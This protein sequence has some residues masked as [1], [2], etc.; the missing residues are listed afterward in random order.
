M[1]LPRVFVRMIDPFSAELAGRSRRRGPIFVGG[2]VFGPD[3]PRGA[4]QATPEEI[5]D[6]QSSHSADAERMPL[7]LAADEQAVLR[8]TAEQVVSARVARCIIGPVQL[9]AELRR[10]WRGDDA[11]LIEKVCQGRSTRSAT[12]IQRRESHDPDTLAGYLTRAIT[13]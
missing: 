6:M 9:R 8:A 3:T 13:S 5:A 4:R 7:Q 1:R 10:F 11:L 2:A 12:R